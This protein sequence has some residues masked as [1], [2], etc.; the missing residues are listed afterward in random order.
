MSTQKSNEHEQSK[1]IP[2]VVC[3]KNP[4][5]ESMNVFISSEATNEELEMVIDSIS[6]Y[7]SKNKKH[8]YQ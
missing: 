7:L 6:S 4:D 5:G 8:N 3:H 2:V 1:G